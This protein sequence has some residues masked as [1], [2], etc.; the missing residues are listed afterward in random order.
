MSHFSAREGQREMLLLWSSVVIWCSITQN[1]R[2]LRRNHMGSGIT[3]MGT[4]LDTIVCLSFTDFLIRSPKC[5]LSV[6]RWYD[7]CFQYIIQAIAEISQSFSRFELGS[8]FL[9][10]I[11][12]MYW[13]CLQGLFPMVMMSPKLQ[14]YLSCRVVKPASEP[15]H[16]NWGA[17]VGWMKLT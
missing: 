11:W 2:S 5:P 12:N 15:G 3:F 4:K 13:S 17:Q 7:Q 6:S 10:E 16:V 14:L 1:R 8:Q 9:E